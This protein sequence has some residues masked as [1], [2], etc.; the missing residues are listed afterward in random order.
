M[1]GRPRATKGRA[2]LRRAGDVLIAF[3]LDVGGAED[4][5]CIHA[6]A[7]VCVCYSTCACA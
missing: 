7:M 3:P 6:L 1:E 4:G 5:V 2:T